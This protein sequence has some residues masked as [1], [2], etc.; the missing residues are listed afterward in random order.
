MILVTDDTGFLGGH[1]VKRLAAAGEK[2]RC[3][4]PK[5]S[6]LKRLVE[7]GVELYPGDL[8]DLA[9][10]GEAI[11]GVD[12]IV[13]LAGGFGAG[14]GIMFSEVHVEGTRNLLAVATRAGI[15]RFVYVS[16]IGSRPDPS[17]PF[18]SSKWRGEAV[19]R[20][21]GLPFTILRP[22]AIFGEGDRFISPLARVVQRLPL[23][24]LVG[25]RNRLQPVWVG[26]VASCILKA[27]AESDLAGRAVPVA[28]P[29]AFTPEEIV[30]L[31]LQTLALKRFLLRLPPFCLSLI[32]ASFLAPGLLDLLRSEALV[33]P[34]FLKKTFGLQPM[35]LSEGMEYILHS[36]QAGG[37]GGRPIASNPARQKG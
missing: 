25:G 29:E 15:E 17:L 6:T 10:L 19:V 26:D 9:S 18:L 30:R 37:T 16:V 31:I 8:K 1:L 3:L 4:I 22:S 24:P 2:V 5:G 36:R 34:D 35:P 20:E 33:E 14:K 21:S 13:H 7:L 11:A 28:G 27:L 23:V 12:R 32:P